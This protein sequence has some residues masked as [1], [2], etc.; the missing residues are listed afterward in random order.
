ML[1]SLRGLESIDN[2]TLRVDH[3]LGSNP[4]ATL[5]DVRYLLLNPH[6]PSGKD[7]LGLEK[8]PD[9]VLKH[10][11][12]DSET[13]KD[14][15]HSG[16]DA[17]I[18]ELRNAILRTLPGGLSISV[19]LNRGICN[20]NR[21]T[22]P[23]AIPNIWT[24]EARAV[25]EPTLLK[26][27]AT[28]LNDTDKIMAGVQK[29]IRILCL[30]SM[31]PWT[32][33]EGARPALSPE[34]FNAYVAAQG[35]GAEYKEPRLEDFIA[36]RKDGPMLADAEFYRVMKQEFD[37]HKIPWADNAPYDTEPGYPDWT[38]MNTFPGRVS[39]IDLNKT[40]LCQGGYS[41]FDPRNHVV[42]PVKVAF[43]AELHRFALRNTWPSQS[44]SKA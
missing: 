4:K 16:R 32:F 34:T 30:H 3:S 21:D 27:H 38:Y 40:R 22:G 8:F 24:P 36:G 37:A 1:S 13:L 7:Q 11:N 23:A 9:E 15:L 10:L 25:V 35:L 2:D 41:T 17:G 18:N 43:M 6:D 42:D 29:G 20:A 12:Y 28:L 5:K 26:M 31:D 39:A 33:K 44:T 14:Y 19:E